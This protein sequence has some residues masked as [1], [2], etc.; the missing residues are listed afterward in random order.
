MGFADELKQR[1]W[2]LRV[3]ERHGRS[4]PQGRGG[5]EHERVHLRGEQGEGHRLLHGRHV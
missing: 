1:E 3:L 5:H 2:P 4:S